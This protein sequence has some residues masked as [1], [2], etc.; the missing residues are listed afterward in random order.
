MAAAVR[1]WPA[2][3]PDD[4]SRG[5]QHEQQRA[6][7]GTFFASTAAAAAASPGATTHGPATEALLEGAEYGPETEVVAGSSDAAAAA[8]AGDKSTQSQLCSIGGTTAVRPELGL[9]TPPEATN[10]GPGFNRSPGAAPGGCARGC[11]FEER[12]GPY[13]RTE[14]DRSL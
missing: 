10:T 8:A 4:D 11:G 2:A 7:Q 9:I 13:A 5:R 3:A 14:G 12:V 1:V 6:K